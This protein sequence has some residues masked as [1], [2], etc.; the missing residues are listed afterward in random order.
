MTIVSPE[1]QATR[2]GE[3]HGY[4]FEGDY[5][6]LN[7]D[8]LFSDADLGAG[9][10][11]SLQLWARETGFSDAQLSG[12]NVARAI[13]ADR[14]LRLR[15]HAKPRGWDSKNWLSCVICSPCEA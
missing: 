2:L 14:S 1:S 8:V 15:I 6:Y 4:R 13:I 3:N 7:A 9:Q 11:W 5:A 12:S 10:A